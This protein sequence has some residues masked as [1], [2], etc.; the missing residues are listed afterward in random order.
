[1]ELAQ[2]PQMVGICFGHQA[3][4]DA[5]GGRV[6]LNSRFVI[7]TE[8]VRPNE[9]YRLASPLRAAA[10]AHSLTLAG[11]R[12]A[13]KP[14]VR[15]AMAELGLVE[16]PDLVHVLQSHGDAVHAL[17]PGAELLASSPDTEV[18][19]FTIGDRIMGIQGHP[20]FAPEL[21]KGTVCS[22]VMAVRAPVISF[23]LTRLCFLPSVYAPQR[24]YSTRWWVRERPPRSSALRS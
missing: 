17:P 10:C 11:A 20:E 18:E 12:F 22:V 4:S 24:K 6:A 16:L 5:L 8:R 19:M 15:M 21:L 7:G 9:R 2:G 1:M 13:E 3:I 23:W 14:Y